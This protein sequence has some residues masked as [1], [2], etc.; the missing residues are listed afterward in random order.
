MRG[1]ANSPKKQEESE[2][3]PTDKVKENIK[4]LG[5]PKLT[6]SE[7][8]IVKSHHEFH[9]DKKIKIMALCR[10]SVLLSESL[11]IQVMKIP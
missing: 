2:S 3:M 9:G 6:K 10:I 8:A 11:T 7:I 5:A 4:K 1:R